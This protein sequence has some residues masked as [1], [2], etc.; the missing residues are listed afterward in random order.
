MKGSTAIR[1]VSRPDM[2]VI[3]INN[4]AADGQTQAQTACLGGPEGIKQLG[5]LRARQ[6]GAVVLDGK[7]HLVGLRLV[8]GQ[9]AG[10]YGDMSRMIV[11]GRRQGFNGIEQQIGHHLLNLNPVGKD[12]GQI[13]LQGQTQINMLTSHLATGQAQQ[14]GQGQVQIKSAAGRCF[15]TG[16]AAYPV[17]DIFGAL[18]VVH[19]PLCGSLCLLH[20]RGRGLQPALTGTRAAVDGGQRLADLMGIST[21]LVVVALGQPQWLMEIDVIAVIPEGWESSKA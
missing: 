14:L 2:A 12:R 18:G 21:G 17:Q 20:I 16:N 19:N 13:G 10:L 5:Q 1:L 6:A 9:E 11:R 7:Q 4:G 8:A 15:V 3:G